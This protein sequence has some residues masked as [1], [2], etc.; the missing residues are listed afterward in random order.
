MEYSNKKP[1]YIG[2]CIASIFANIYHYVKDTDIPIAQVV[3]TVYLSEHNTTYT[4]DMVY[5]ISVDIK[6]SNIENSNIKEPSELLIFKGIMKYGGAKGYVEFVKKKAGATNDPQYSGDKNVK[7]I[8]RD[9]IKNV[10]LQYKLTYKEPNTD[11]INANNDLILLK[12]IDNP[13]GTRAYGKLSP[14]KLYQ[15]DYDI[16]G[17]LLI[18]NLTSTFKIKYLKS[19]KLDSNT[20]IV[21]G[22]FSKWFQEDIN[23]NM[24][25]TWSIKNDLTLSNYSYVPTSSKYYSIIAAAGTFK[26]QFADYDKD[27]IL[28]PF[29]KFV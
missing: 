11:L 23:P 1:L 10:P 12:T 15:L 2:T 7:A 13:S 24:W 9:C 17:K 29:A 5:R 22:E 4:K 28:L 26:I 27:E 18:N 19:I 25:N 8:I 14:N 3:D 16:D 6:D 21:S 20:E